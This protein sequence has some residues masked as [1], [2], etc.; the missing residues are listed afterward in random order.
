MSCLDLHFGLGEASKV[1]EISILWP[2]G[3]RQIL[4]DK[5]VDQVLEI[6]EPAAE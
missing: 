3:V 6:V 4:T 1:N 5:D 2:S